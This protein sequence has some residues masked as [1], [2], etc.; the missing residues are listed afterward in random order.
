ML[1]LWAR[2]ILALVAALSA[3]SLLHEEQ[4]LALVFALA[5]AVF[6]AINA[7]L[8]PANRSKADRTA[9][10]SYRHVERSAGALLGWCNRSG[11][12]CM[13]APPRTAPTRRQ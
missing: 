7:A 8:D 2:L 10:Y 1:D 12:R 4:Q 9:G 11:A 6:S 3:I 5:T 13:S